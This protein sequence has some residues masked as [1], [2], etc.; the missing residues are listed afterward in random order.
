MPLPGQKRQGRNPRYWGYQPRT[1]RAFPASPPR[2]R[3]RPLLADVAAWVAATVVAG[4]LLLLL[5]FHNALIA[6][7]VLLAYTGF[8][9][10]LWSARRG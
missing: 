8:S 5:A 6:A 10:V 7:V 4:A 3:P 1:G 9:W 2:R